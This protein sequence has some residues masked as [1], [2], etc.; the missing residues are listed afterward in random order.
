M[1]ENNGFRRALRN[2]LLVG[3]LC[4]TAGVAMY[5][6]YADTLTSDFVSPVDPLSFPPE[7]RLPDTAS[8]P[9]LG[10]PDPSAAVW[11]KPSL[12]DPFSPVGVS[13]PSFS[14]SEATN[15]A[16]VSAEPR[17]PSFQHMALKAIA[18]E[19]GVKSAVIN[20]T[21][22]Y[23]GDIMEGFH[24][25]SIEANGVWLGQGRHKHFLTFEERKVS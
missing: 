11:G 17:Q 2:P 3:G 4:L 23:E 18:L 12:R 8:S 24:V 22:V 10:S 14:Y 21:I 7:R 6:N 19:D 9:S 16:T 5:V 25:L 13:S 1:D 20:R 15:D